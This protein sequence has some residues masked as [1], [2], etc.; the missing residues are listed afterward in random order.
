MRTTLPHGGMT[1]M[2]H[3]RRRDAAGPPLPGLPPPAT[4]DR[5]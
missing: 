4:T 5:A 2:P 3:A 1:D